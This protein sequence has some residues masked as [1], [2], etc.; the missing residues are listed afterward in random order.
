MQLM[1]FNVSIREISPS[2][3]IAAVVIVSCVSRS[4][5]KP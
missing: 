5:S 2:H 1:D 4:R 3:S